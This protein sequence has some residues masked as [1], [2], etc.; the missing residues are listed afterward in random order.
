MKEEIKNYGKVFVLMPFS[1]E[2]K[3]L[4]VLGIKNPLQSIGF[5]C[6]RVD[7]QHFEDLIVE[8]IQDQ[9]RSADYIIGVTDSL[10]PNVFY[11]IG[12]SHALQKKTILISNSN[13][14]IPFDLNQYPH[15]IYKNISDLKEKITAKFDNYKNNP[16]ITTDPLDRLE[17]YISGLSLSHTNIRTNFTIDSNYVESKAYFEEYQTVNIHF[18]I[19]NNSNIEFKN[20]LQLGLEIPK[21]IGLIPIKK[22]KSFLTKQKTLMLMS[23]KLD[24]I[25]PRSISKV[26]FQYKLEKNIT[27][28]QSIKF[29]GYLHLYSPLGK[30]EFAVK[31]KA[32]L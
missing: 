4:Y 7:E 26:N 25:F 24:T 19:E 15:I 5:L 11:E 22:E 1:D 13:L 14:T 16:K 20:S 28:N 27:K 6:D 29:D 10:N 30:R 8:R 18:E 9:I 32:S 2:F 3:D 23:E 31:G 12:Y 21:S 17:I